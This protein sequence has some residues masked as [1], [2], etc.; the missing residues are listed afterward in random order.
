MRPLSARE[1]RLLCWKVK[2]GDKLP[3]QKLFAL[4]EALLQRRQPRRRRCANDNRRQQ[5]LPCNHRDVLF[6]AYTAAITR[7]M[8]KVS[9][10]GHK[11]GRKAEDYPVLWREVVA[12]RAA[13]AR[14]HR[15]YQRHISAHHCAD[16]YTR[17]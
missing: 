2:R 17:K 1:V 6:A 15:D 5:R 11:A 16:P 4:L 8:Q 13:T 7:W 10:L 3:R 9:A 14:A 12:A